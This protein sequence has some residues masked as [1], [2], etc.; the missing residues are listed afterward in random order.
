MKTTTS[1]S[2]LL[3]EGTTYKEVLKILEPIYRDPDAQDGQAGA[4]AQPHWPT[5]G[6]QPGTLSYLLYEPDINSQ[7]LNLLTFSF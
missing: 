4:M 2:V 3:E 6:A 7:L 5:S 1:L